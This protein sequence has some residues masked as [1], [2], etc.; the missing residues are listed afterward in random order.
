MKRFEYD[1]IYALRTYSQ[2]KADDLI[3]DLNRRGEKGW[4][5]ICVLDQTMIVLKREIL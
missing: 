5:I 3:K 4:E 2:I 1:Y